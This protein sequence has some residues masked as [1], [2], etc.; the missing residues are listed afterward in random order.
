MFFY[1]NFSKGF[2]IGVTWDFM[3][4]NLNNWKLND[5]PTCNLQKYYPPDFDPSKVP[6]G[7]R[8]KNATFNIRIMAPFNMRYGNY[9]TMIS[10]KTTDKLYV[11]EISE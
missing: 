6:R 11:K 9:V 3:V 4:K 10:K 2:F 1:Q 8:N 7:K 5:D